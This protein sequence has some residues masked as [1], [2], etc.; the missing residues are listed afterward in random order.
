MKKLLSLLLASLLLTQVF[1]SCAENTEEISPDST[2]PADPSA[3]VSETEEETE[4]TRENIPDN[5]P[6]KNFDGRTFTLLTRETDGIYYGDKFMPEEL[7]GEG[8][9]DALYDRNIKIEERFG[10]DF[11]YVSKNSQWGNAQWNNEMTNSIM[12]GDGAYDLIAAYA[13]T[14]SENISKNIFLNWREIPNIDLTQPWWS[15][16]AIDALTVNGRSYLITGDYAL[17]MWDNMFAFIFNKK[18][19]SDFGVEN[20]YDLVRS[21]D[22][23]LDKMSEITSGVS[24]D[25]NGD[26]Q[27]TRDD[28]YGLITDWGTSVDTF[29]VA[30]DMPVVSHTDDGS[31]EVALY[32]EKAVSIVEKLN[33]LYHTTHGAFMESPDNYMNDMFRGD[34]ALLYATYF[35]KITALRDM[36]SDF[37]ILPYPKYDTAQES[38]SSTSRDN[39]DL[40]VVPIDVKDTEFT[41]IITEALCAESYRSVVPKYYDVVL[42][43]KTSRDEESAEMIDIIRDNLTFDIGYLCSSTLSGIGHIFVN[44]LRNNSND[45]SS[46][47]TASEKPAKKLLEKMLVSYG[48]E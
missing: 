15:Q 16:R 13:A 45:L 20:L 1:V 6:E 22:W 38:Y 23:T 25:I 37:G 42:K 28:I 2:V 43:S 3:A 4:I 8:V 10:V 18:L 29:Q 36:E 27:W 9:N 40:F 46:K 39:F 24:I 44:L 17:S 5:L 47:F 19:A 35:E 33:N 26:G 12:A 34:R 48:I 11:A 31:L 21:G 7:N 32:S 14:A 41:G 30:F